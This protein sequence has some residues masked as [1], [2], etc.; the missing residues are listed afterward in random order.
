MSQLK[1]PYTIISPI[2]LGRKVHNSGTVHLTEAEARWE[3]AAGRLKK[4]PEM[5]ERATPSKP[6]R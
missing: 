4:Q 5:A 6:K 2:R 3:V 1:E